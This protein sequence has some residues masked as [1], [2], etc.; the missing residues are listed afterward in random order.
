MSPTRGSG[1]HE[2]HNRAFWDADAQKLADLGCDSG[3]GFLF[4][5]P[6][7]EQELMSM[8]MA[9]RTGSAFTAQLG[10]MKIN[11]EIDALDTMGVTPEEI[12]LLP[13]LVG[14]FIALPLLTMWADIFGIL[15][16]MVMA[17]NMLNINFSKD[18][19]T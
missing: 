10:I 16:G 11:Q 6:M 17:N 13:R 18:S 2:Q 15:G 7:T 9:G 3:Q 5:K 12:L 1:D 8:V 14:L 19:L 4:A